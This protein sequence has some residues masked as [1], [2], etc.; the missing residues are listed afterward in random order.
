MELWNTKTK[1]AV[2]ACLDREIHMKKYLVYPKHHTN[3]KQ[4]PTHLPRRGSGQTPATTTPR[5]GEPKEELG[6]NKR[7]PSPGT[8]PAPPVL[9]T[10]LAPR[11]LAGREFPPF[12]IK[13]RHIYGWR[14]EN[15]EGEKHVEVLTFH[16]FISIVI[17]HTTKLNE[18]LLKKN[19]MM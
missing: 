2:R 11:R 13:V 1:S 5:P 4:T 15:T 8:A 19:K 12:R 18:P 14:G 9:T 6:P 16:V 10:P 7:G 3:K 17:K